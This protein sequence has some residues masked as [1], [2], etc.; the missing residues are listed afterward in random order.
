MLQLIWL[1]HHL[2]NVGNNAVSHRRLLDAEDNNRTCATEADNDD[3][4]D[5]IIRRV[6]VADWQ[7]SLWC[8]SWLLMPNLLLFSLLP[9]LLLL[10]VPQAALLRWRLPSLS[11]SASQQDNWMYEWRLPE[12]SAYVCLC[13]CGYILWQCQHMWQMMNFLLWQE[14]CKACFFSQVCFSA[15]LHIHTYPSMRRCEQ[16]SARVCVRVCVFLWLAAARHI[17]LY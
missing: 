9:L 15:L 10:S 8:Y 7:L 17:R 3:D 12:V 11:P 4:N 14:V 16:T 5:Y 6:L 1:L 13:V 2:C